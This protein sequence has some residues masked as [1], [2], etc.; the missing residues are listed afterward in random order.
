MSL[1]ELGWNDYFAEKSVA[2]NDKGWNAGRI[3]R[4]KKNL[5]W[6]YSENGEEMAIMSDKLFLSIFSSVE[7]PAIG[8][9]VLFRRED[10]FEKVIIE[11]ILPRKSKFSRK[12]KDSYG[13]NYCKDGSSDEQIISANIDTVFLVMSLDRDFNLRKLERYLALI[14]DSGSNPVIVLNKA[15]QCSE[16]EYFLEEAKS[17][18]QGMPVHVIS[19]LE[20][21]GIEELLKYIEPGKTITFVGSSGVGKSA[22]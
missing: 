15:D 21:Y 6:L 4:E 5:Y 14:W 1:E 3:A 9:W 10:N 2:Y 18:I 8:D 11:T 17:V 16:V 19:A 22:T 12:G 20:N 13:R 7:L